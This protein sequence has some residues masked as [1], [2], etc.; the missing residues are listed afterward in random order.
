MFHIMLKRTSL[1]FL[2]WISTCANKIWQ[3]QIS[4]DAFCIFN[5]IHLENDI[6]FSVYVREP[7]TH[8]LALL[9]SVKRQVFWV[10]DRLK[11]V[12]HK[13]WAT[14]IV[15]PKSVGSMTTKGQM[16]PTCRVSLTASQAGED[17][18]SNVPEHTIVSIKCMKITNFLDMSRNMTM[19]LFFQWLHRDIEIGQRDQLRICQNSKHEINWSKTSKLYHAANFLKGAYQ[20]QTEI[21]PTASVLWNHQ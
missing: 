20:C 9:P 7:H 16:K 13:A 3:R 12:K 19:H 8:T 11:M 6:H 5:E 17:S 10:G 4:F 2:N 21:V 18:Q 15:A 14:T 1:Y